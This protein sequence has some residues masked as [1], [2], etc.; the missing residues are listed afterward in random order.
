MRGSFGVLAD[1]DA[2]HA[3][4]TAFA[5]CFFMHE[6]H[7]GQDEEKIGDKQ[8]DIQV[9]RNEAEQRRHQAV[10]YIGAGHLYAD[11]CL[12]VFCPEPFRR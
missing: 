1:T 8:P 5:D 3:G 9:L 7:G 2:L 4:H 12:G 6:E 10:S 11:D